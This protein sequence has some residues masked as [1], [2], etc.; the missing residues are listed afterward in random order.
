M[1]TATRDLRDN[2]PA[3]KL[4]LRDLNYY[5]DDPHKKRWYEYLVA[6]IVAEAIDNADEPPPIGGDWLEWTEYAAELREDAGAMRFIEESTSMA[7]CAALFTGWKALMVLL[8]SDNYHAWRDFGDLT[9]DSNHH[10]EPWQ[11]QAELALNRDVFEL[12]GEV[13]EAID[14]HA[15]DMEPGDDD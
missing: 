1:T 7:H 12:Y 9:A 2:V 15:E 13:C 4:V 10:A 3:V 8:H 6:A 11:L 14:E 5:S